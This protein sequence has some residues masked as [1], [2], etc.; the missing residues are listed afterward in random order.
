MNSDLMFEW[1]GLTRREFCAKVYA[2]RGL[3]VEEKL[4]EDKMRLI[5]AGL[6][7]EFATAWLNHPMG[8]ADAALLIAMVLMTPEQF[9]KAKE[10]MQKKVSEANKLN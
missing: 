10:V 6:S 8:E 7:P 3:N 5:K 4:K 9:E 1:R 2:K